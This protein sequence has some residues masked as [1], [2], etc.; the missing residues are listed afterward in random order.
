MNG[1][2]FSVLV[3]TIA[4]AVAPCVAQEPAAVG[5]E[6]PDQPPPAEGADLTFSVSAGYQYIF[7]TDLDVG[8]SY[9]VDRLGLE[10]K[11]KSKLSSEWA[12]EGNLKYLFN[13]YNFN[14]APA[15]G[16]DP[17]SDIH[18]LELDVQAQ[19]WPANDI[20][21][22]FGPFI[23]WSRESGSSW[24]DAVTGGG[25][26]GVMFISSP[27]LIWGGGIGVSSQIEDSVLVYPI[28]IL[29]W[30]FHGDMKVSSVAG[31]VGLSFTGLEWVWTFAE[32]W[33]F[34]VGGRYEYRRFRLDN[35][36]FAPG[37]VGQ[38][39]S[40]PFWAR[41]S[42]RL[43]KQVS[44]D[45]YAGMVAGGNFR[46]ENLNGVRL[47]EDDSGLAPTLAVTVRVNF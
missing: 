7:R 29:D 4:A 28:I 8:G 43:D 24:G 23:E 6:P 42:F 1:R 34:G 39:T 47:G 9:A 26:G 20:M 2:G 17:W 14:S 36:G 11:T 3:I 38:D 13:D 46:V 44:A 5:D 27:N 41:V 37:G 30:K 12:L 35:S 16:G 19:W 40:I 21:V 33:E 31:P 25:F 10:L 15:L 32:H 18:I 22:F 45:L